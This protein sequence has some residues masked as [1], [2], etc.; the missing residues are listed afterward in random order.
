MQ[1]VKNLHVEVIGSTVGED[2]ADA[3][4]NYDEN[5]L[6]VNYKDDEVSLIDLF[7][8]SRAIVSFEKI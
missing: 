3:T 5:W 2:F 1:R 4:I 8:A 6:I 7:P